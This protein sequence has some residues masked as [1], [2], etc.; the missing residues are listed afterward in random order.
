MYIPARFLSEFMTFCFP[1]TGLS[2][3]LPLLFAVLVQKGPKKTAG[4]RIRE[5][6]ERRM[7]MNPSPSAHYV[8]SFHIL[9]LAYYRTGRYDQTVAAVSRA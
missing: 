7:S 2:K 3:P 8:W 6:A 4:D 9:E 5:L 1:S